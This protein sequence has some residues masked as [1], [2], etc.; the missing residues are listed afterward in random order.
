MEQSIILW[1]N[2]HI[3]IPGT[4]PLYNSENIEYIDTDITISVTLLPANHCPGSVMFMF[5]IETKNGDSKTILHT[6]DFRCDDSIIYHPLL[7]L[8]QRSTGSSTLEIVYLDT[9]YD[10]PAWCFPS[11][12]TILTKSSQ[13]LKRVILQ[14]NKRKLAPFSYLVVIGCYTIGK[15]RIAIHLA[16]TLSCKIYCQPFKRKIF[17]CYTESEWSN[18]FSLIEDNPLNAMIHLVPM[19]WLKEEKL[20]ELLCTYRTTFTHIIAIHPTGWA[21]AKKSKKNDIDIFPF[22]KISS[23]NFHTIDSQ[24]RPIIKNDRIF[25]YELPYSEH[26]SYQELERFRESF[27]IKKIIPTV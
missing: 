5:I 25:L 4:L 17:N 21:S 27:I 20:S 9:T 12:N 10:D 16:D 14:E 6:G 13:Y 15:E 18:L 26:S 11:Q 3:I 7:T 23:L 24:N 1:K 2:N 22:T 8:Y 19:D